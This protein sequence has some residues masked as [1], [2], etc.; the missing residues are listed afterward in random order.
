MR[1]STSRTCPR[2]PPSTTASIYVQTG[3]RRR[4][5]GEPGPIVVAIHAHEPPASPFKFVQQFRRYPVARMQH[6]TGTFDGGP[7][8]GGQLPGPVG[9]VRIGDK[10]E[11]QRHN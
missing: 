3:S 10:K 7:G 4:S 2:R 6:H 1:T 8:L 5:V 9:N 11:A